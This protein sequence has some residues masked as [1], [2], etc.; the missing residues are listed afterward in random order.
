MTENESMRRKL[1]ALYEVATF[2]PHLTLL[3]VALSFV[4]AI[5]EGVGISFIMPIIEMA[6]NPSQTPESGLAAY[7]VRVYRALGIPFNLEFI[8]LGTTVVMAVRFFTSFLVGWLRALLQTDYVRTLQ[9]DAFKGALEA[10]VPYFDKEGSDEILNTIIT[11]A[12]YAGRAIKWIIQIVQEGLLTL[13]YL[14]LALY[15]AP[16][17]TLLTIVVLGTS[18]YLVRNRFE[19]GYSVG[20]QV[21]DANEKIQET[22]QAG[23]QGIRDV[24]L[25]GMADELYAD[26]QTAVDKYADYTIR[27]YRNK[28]AINNATQFTISATVFVLIYL[29]LRF[30]SLSLGSLGV[31]LFAMFRLGPRVSTLNNYIYEAEGDLPHLIRTQAFI[32]ELERHREQTL[33]ESESELDEVTEVAFDRVWFAYENDD[34]VLSDVSFSLEKGDFVAFVGS[35]GAGK[36]TIVSLLTYMY[37][38]D[39][40]TIRGNGE[41]V[42]SYD[43]RDWRSRIAVVRQNPYLFNDTLRYNITVG[44]DDVSREKLRRVCDIAQVTE[45]LDDLPEGFDTHLGDSGVRLSGGQRQRVAIARALLKD[46]DVLVLDE[47]TS[48]LDTKLEERVHAGIGS[49][50]NDYAVL[51]VA[52]RLSTVTDADRIYTMSDGNIIESGPHDELLSNDGLYASLYGT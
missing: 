48:D 40:G 7:F 10:Q 38:P 2:R 29:G 6:R 33:G 15:I 20:N 5:L 19:A 21:A 34:Y 49:L 51:V 42:S 39:E 52:H 4:A 26:F 28:T 17:L 11:E 50:D 32:D 23:T 37:K 13:M 41:D 46:A 3:V 14:G 9:S 18:V 45:F 27:L 12:T 22:T 31:F 47:A 43:V 16:V 1:A 30:A 36:S 24:K 44:K 8:I 25:N 35:S